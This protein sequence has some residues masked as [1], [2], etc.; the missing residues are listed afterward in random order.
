MLKSQLILCLI[1]KLIFTTI[2][3]ASEPV[4]LVDS[5]VQKV[6]L[7]ELFSSESCSSCPP[8]DQWFS[9]LQSHPDLWKKFVPIVFH[10]DY[11]NHLNWKDDFSSEP[12][13]KR[14]IQISQLWTSPRVYTPAVVVD[15]NE[16]LGWRNSSADI[17]PSRAQSQKISLAVYKEKNS[18]ENF[19]VQV[20]GHDPT[21]KY[22]L[23]LALLG[24]GLKTQVISGE[25]SGKTLKHDFIL[26]NWEQQAI[27]S[28][29]K[30][31]SFKIQ[32]PKNR[33]YSRLALSVWIELSGVPTSL[34]A[35]G[36]YL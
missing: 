35:V 32:K 18:D 3:N 17:P 36:T 28:K 2:T 34:Q 27:D 6:Q 4:L 1:L 15:G 29:S 11:W 22:I 7:V 8:A 5:G 33:K 21:K 30:L 20:T 25:N 13:T 19:K 26:L 23:K 9:K 31:T 12:M 16:W 10:V 24:M 14:Q